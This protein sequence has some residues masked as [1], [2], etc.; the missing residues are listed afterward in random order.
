MES[1]TIVPDKVARPMKFGGLQEV[2]EGKSGTT[3][4][5]P[6]PSLE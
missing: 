1:T 5:N 6:D 3:P 2:A 4:K